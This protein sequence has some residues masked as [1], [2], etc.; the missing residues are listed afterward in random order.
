MTDGSSFLLADD[1]DKND[2][3]NQITAF[4]SLY[5]RGLLQKEVLVRFAC[6]L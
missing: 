1:G 6:V 4:L 5:L 2:D 3:K